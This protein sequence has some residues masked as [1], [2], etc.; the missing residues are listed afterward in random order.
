MPLPQVLPVARVVRLTIPLQLIR[1]RLPIHYPRKQY[2]VAPPAPRLILALLP[3]EPALTGR[4]PIAVIYQG[5]YPPVQAIYRPKQLP[6]TGIVVTRWFIPLCPVPT[7]AMW[8]Q[9][10]IV[11]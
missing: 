11:L 7:A 1:C 8:Q 6:I 2:A 9:P 5:S 10:T 3:G 4:L